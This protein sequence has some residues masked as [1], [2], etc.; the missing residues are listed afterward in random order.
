MPHRSPTPHFTA[1]QRVFQR[2]YLK[3]SLGDGG[4]GIVWLAQ[5]RVLEQEVALKFLLPHLFND[6]AAVER[7]KHETRRNLKLSHPNIV[8]IHDFLQDANCAAITMEFVEGWSLAAMK[9]DKPHQIFSA[10]EIAPWVRELLDALDYAHNKVGI[11]HRDLKPGNLMVDC[12]GQIKITDFGLAGTLK[13]TTSRDFVD[14]RVVGTEVYMSPEQWSGH[15]PAVAD[16]IYSIGATLYELLTGKPPFYQGDIQ[17]QVY[18]AVPPK[19]NARLAELGVRDVEIPARYEE[20]VA[21][22]LEKHPAD[23]PASVKE[24]AERLG[25]IEVEKKSAPEPKPPPQPAPAPE[26]L[27]KAAPEIAAPVSVETKSEP[28]EIAPPASEPI[29]PLPPRHFHVTMKMGVAAGF[30]CALIIGLAGWILAAKLS[31]EKFSSALALP[32]PTDFPEPG[33][34]WQNSLGMKLVP[35]PGVNGLMC[36]WETRVRDFEIYVRELGREPGNSML[37]LDSSNTWKQLSYSWRNP[38]FEQ[39]SNHPVVGISWNDAMAFC[40]WLTIRERVAG[41]ITTNESYRLPTSAEWLKAAG[42]NRF[43]W[44]DQWPPPA[45]AGNFAGEEIRSRFPNHPFIAGYNDGFGGT[46]PVGNFAANALGIFDLAGNVAEYCQ[47]RDEKDRM[48]R[49]FVAGGSWNDA[50]DASLERTHFGHTREGRRVSDC[51]FRVILVF[52]NAAADAD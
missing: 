29:S 22:C 25:L 10:E 13:K 23:R 11:V 30:F 2:F 45:G 1:G 47:D 14:L 51:G 3:R 52:R 33:K 28:E 38:E 24:I 35:V 7:L 49:R 21:A 46:S 50:T 41:W 17:Q 48:R 18:E 4:S 36:V 37:S 44:G 15:P 5:D 6:R 20:T 19:M 8:R 12:R 40:D 31:K 27:I 43:V 16:D 32:A 9:L 34:P 39:N 26:P 42:E